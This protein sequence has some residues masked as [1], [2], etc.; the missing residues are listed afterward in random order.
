LYL[1]S[2]LNASKNLQI[3]KLFLFTFYP[4]TDPNISINL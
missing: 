4:T 1:P 2:Y 3:T